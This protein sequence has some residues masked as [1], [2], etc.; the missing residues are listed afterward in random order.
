MSLLNFD[1]APQDKI[2]TEDVK[3]FWHHVLFKWDG[4][5]AMVCG[6]AWIIFYY[7]AGYMIT[8]S[9]FLL[10]AL[11]CFIIACFRA[12]TELRAERNRAQSELA[13]KIG[14]INAIPNLAG[15][16]K[17]I[18]DSLTLSISHPVPTKIKSAF[19]YDEVVH[20]LDGD[21]D[22]KTRLFSYTAE[23]RNEKI[24]SRKYTTLHGSMG[25]L[26]P[27]ILVTI[28]RGTNG[29]GE[30]PPNYEEGGVLDRLTSG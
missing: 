8:S 23:R 24:P 18:K 11:V 15:K 22:P 5:F 25:L 4:L 16:W 20:D 13:A 27:N 9:I 30:L 2:W 7:G 12:H 17:R 29:A 10:I 1:K 6:G 19:T 21:Y 26:T 28:V 3:A 14:E